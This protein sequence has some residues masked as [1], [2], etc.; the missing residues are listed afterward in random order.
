MRAAYCTG[1]GRIEL[2]DVAT[3][4][5]EAGDALVAIHACGICGSDLHYWNGALPP[6]AVCLGHEISGRVVSGGAL[7]AGA[8]VVV[9]PLLACGTCAR[10]RAGEPNL[11]ARLRILGSMAPGGF[12]DYVA[13]PDRVLYPVPAGL[14]LDAAMLAEPL[15]VGV[16]ASEI[17]AIDAGEAVLVLG[18]GAI[19]LLAGAAAAERGAAVTVSARHAHQARAAATLGLGAIGTS[20]EEIRDRCAAS[21]PDV[22]L[23]TVGGT[24]ATLDLALDV[25]RP[26]GRIVA[27]GKFT[28]SIALPP[29]RFLMKEVRLT[30]SM[31]YCRRARPS[32]FEAALALLARD[33][34]R[35]T[36]LIT[37]R[38]ALADAADAF[39]RAA[40]KPSGAIKVAVM[41]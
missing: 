33:R 12:A 15:A 38:V 40:D 35:F 11:C 39:A 8:P 26:G 16:H 28:Q 13:V 27:L 5:P 29:L 7:P 4:R 22:V 31:T 34:E 3:P 17:G 2:R 23:E 10:C 1:P 30:S 9:E 21:P 36:S 6:P 25:V 19:G 20:L 32:D 41:P 18:A 37:A 24:A 14:D